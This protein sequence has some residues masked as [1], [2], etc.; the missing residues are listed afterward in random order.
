MS[1]I[2]D[3]PIRLTA[4]DEDLVDVRVIVCQSKAGRAAPLDQ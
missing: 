2:N 3:F 1:Q 4:R